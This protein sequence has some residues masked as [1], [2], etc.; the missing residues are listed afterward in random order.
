MEDSFVTNQNLEISGSITSSGEC[1]AVRIRDR[2]KAYQIGWSL[3][4]LFG[5]DIEPSHTVT[6]I[7]S[8]PGFLAD[9]RKYNR[10]VEVS[11]RAAFKNL[12]P[13]LADRTDSAGEFDIQYWF[14][15]L[16]AARKVCALMPDHHV[17]IGSRIDGF[18]AHVLSYLPVTV[19]DIRPGPVSVIGL[20]FI[21]SD[22]TS[23]RGIDN[24]SVSSLSSLHAAEHFGL[25]RYG[26]RIDPE[27]HLKFMS[28]LSR[29]L[30]PGGTL[31]FSVPTGA[32]RVH[33]NAHRVLSPETVLNAFSSLRLVSFSAVNDNCEFVENCEPATVSE[34]K[35]ACGLYEFTK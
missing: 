11:P 29:V 25:G 28:S 21:C 14:Q 33:F 19:V 4:S 12:H 13:I 15:D 6:A 10:L 32:E 16:W 35:Y 27:G 5:V 22:A 24:D 7:K 23:L 3:L 9:W 34:A 1:R 17:D 2:S 26:D 30:K 18:V 20:N 8:L 31:L